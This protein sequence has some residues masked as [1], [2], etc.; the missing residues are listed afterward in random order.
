MERGVGPFAQPEPYAKLRC[1]SIEPRGG[2]FASFCV[3]GM[4]TSKRFLTPVA[5]SRGSLRTPAADHFATPA[6]Q[7]TA[8]PYSLSKL[9]M[10]GWFRDLIGLTGMAVPT[11]VGPANGSQ[12]S[13]ARPNIRRCLPRGLFVLSSLL[14]WSLRGRILYRCK[15]CLP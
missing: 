4:P 3:T 13:S 9:A 1:E 10:V 11:Y 12:V 15:A 7:S 14:V 5:P 2:P 6:A 8:E